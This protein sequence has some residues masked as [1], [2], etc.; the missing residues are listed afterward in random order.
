MEHYQIIQIDESTWALDEGM[1]RSYLLAGTE[2]AMLI[3]TGMGAGELDKV[4]ASLTKLPIMLVNTHAD[5]DHTGRNDLFGTPYLHPS[6]FA[7][8]ED[9]NPWKPHLAVPDNAKIYLGD[10]WVEVILVPGHTPGSIALLDEERRMLF[11]GDTVSESPIYMFGP[12][13]SLFAYFASMERLERQ[14]EYF[15]KIYPSHGPMPLE[16]EILGRLAACC[17]AALS[18]KLEAQEPPYKVPA[19]YYAQDGVGFLLQ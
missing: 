7:S 4:V 9:R 19:R 1:V 3:D 13:R 15:D 16:P 6:E 17:E 2:R 5:P 14:A 10:R 8:Y 12:G 18:G 11:A